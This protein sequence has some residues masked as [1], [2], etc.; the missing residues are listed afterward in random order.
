LDPVTITTHGRPIMIHAQVRQYKI[1]SCAQRGHVTVKLDG[2][3]LTDPSGLGMASSYECNAV[4]TLNATLA[5][6]AGAHTLELMVKGDNG[7]VCT[8]GTF[9][10][11]YVY[12]LP[13]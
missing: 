3:L 1:G 11:L 10:F 7:G 4:A 9:D 12:E 8:Y 13:N 5:V 6:S 2:Q